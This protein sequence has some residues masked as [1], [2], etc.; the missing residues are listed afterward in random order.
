[1]D[2]G[3]TTTANRDIRVPRVGAAQGSGRG[4]GGG[5]E[6]VVV[7][8]EGAEAVMVAWVE[9]EMGEFGGGWEPRRRACM[10]PKAR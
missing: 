4:G 7:V 1:M 3:T 5:G 10:N 8:G 9:F 2:S 6:E